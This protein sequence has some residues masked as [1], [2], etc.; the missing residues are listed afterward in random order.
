M[1]GYHLGALTNV[2]WKMCLM[3]KATCDILVFEVSM[4]HW[5]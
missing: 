4:E 2:F 5:K 1:K 3:Y